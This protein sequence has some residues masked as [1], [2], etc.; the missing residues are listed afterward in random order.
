MTH[1]D[2]TDLLERAA[3]RSEVG[4]PP[5]DGMLRRVR[6][7][8]RRHAVLGGAGLTAATVAVAI[9]VPVLTTSHHPGDRPTPTI[10]QPTRSPDV[11]REIDLQGR[12]IVTALVRR[13]G[14]AA[15]VAYHGT[16]FHFVFRRAT[17]HAFDG[18]NE[19]SGGYAVR[20]DRFHLKK[21]VA[22]TLVGCTPGP[23]PLFE[24]LS[25]V[26]TVSRDPGGTYLEDARGN[27][28]IAL[29]RL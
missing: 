20:D 25:D 10:T 15:P 14:A 18:C 24:R 11:H 17:V 23:A 19:L 1:P 8:R 13:G 3:G 22:Q 2:L 7:R 26:R 27:V 6:R 21:N 4:P 16:R 9:A 5:L 29:H 28:V 12:W